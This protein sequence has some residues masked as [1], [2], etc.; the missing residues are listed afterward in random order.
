[1]STIVTDPIFDASKV[2]KTTITII[3]C[4]G[5]TGS[6]L[7]EELVRLG[8]TNFVLYEF[9][10]VEEHNLTNQNYNVADIG[11]PKLDLT[12]EKMKAIDPFVK[13]TPKGKWTGQYL[14]GIVFNCVDSMELR[15]QIYEVNQYNAD[16][17]YILDPRLGSRTGS[18]FAYEWTSNN[19]ETLIKLSDWKDDE[20]DVEVSLCG[21]KINISTTLDMVV[22]YLKVA[23]INYINKDSYYQQVYFSPLNY[24][25]SYLQE[26]KF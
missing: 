18:V 1:M 21:T 26:R 8:C 22:H 5:A 20:M 24:Q 6:H 3:G 4:G 23:F 17:K 7:C 13:I 10:T 25:I 11:K 14:Q 19:A 15:K 2:S 12:I 16:I 9:D